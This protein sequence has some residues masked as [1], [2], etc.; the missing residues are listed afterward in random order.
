MKRFLKKILFNETPPNVI[1]FGVAKGMKVSYGINDRTLHLL[2]LYETEI[3]PFLRKG[4]ESADTLIDIGANDGYYALAFLKTKKKRIIL[5]EPGPIVS[6]LRKN[7]MLNNR[8]EDESVVIQTKLVS[9][10]SNEKEI[11]IN[12]LVNGASRPFIL[13]DV[14]GVEETIVRGYDFELNREKKITWLIETHSL[15][16]EDNIKSLLESNSFEVTIIK[17]AWWRK[18]IPELR[19]LAHNRWMYAEQK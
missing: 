18:M 15:E 1:R 3:Y 16:L 13:M 2:G 8:T 10:R 4:M 11:A 5:C 17:N 14:D 7:L 6:D 12:D 9:N 19:P